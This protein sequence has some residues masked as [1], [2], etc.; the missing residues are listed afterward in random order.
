MSIDVLFSLSIAIALAL[1]LAFE[2]VAPAV[3]AFGIQSAAPVA[4]VINDESARRPW[5]MY[6]GVRSDGL[7][8]L[9]RAN[10]GAKL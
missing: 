1:I 5:A 3:G 6:E 10:S 8:A 2:L 4:T 7:L 9:G